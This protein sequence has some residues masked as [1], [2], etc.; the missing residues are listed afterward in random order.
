MTYWLQI[1]TLPNWFH[2]FNLR[3]SQLYTRWSYTG[4]EHS[5]VSTFCVESEHIYQMHIVDN[6]FS[7]ENKNRL[8]CIQSNLRKYL[9]DS[10]NSIHIKKIAVVAWGI[11]V[12]K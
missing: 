3:N 1:G 10:N 5:L 2:L 8:K 4:F 11:F 9:M 6:L 7:P 12:E